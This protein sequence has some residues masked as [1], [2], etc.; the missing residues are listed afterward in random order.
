V[1]DPGADPQEGS[2]PAVVTIPRWAAILISG[3]SAAV[4][5]VHL[6]F[7]SLRIDGTT[8]ILL[9][10]AV[11]PWA[12]PLIR[13]ARLGPF[14]LNQLQVQSE[15]L[16]RAVT[17]VNERVEEIRRLVVTGATPQQQAR[18]E[19]DISRYGAYLSRI[20]IDGHLADPPI[21]IVHDP[22]EMAPGFLSEYRDGTIF[23]LAEYADRPTVALREYTHHAL[24]ASQL[25]PSTQDAPARLIESG[26]AYYFPC[27]FA[28]DGHFGR[29]TGQPPGESDGSYLQDITTPVP[30]AD[31]HASPLD[32]YVAGGHNWAVKLW[33]LRGQVRARLADPALVEAWFAGDPARRHDFEATFV[34]AVCDRLPSDQAT[35]ARH[36][37]GGRHAQKA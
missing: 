23:I 13:T 14:E 22:G 24:R 32:R 18:L 19:T 3:L 29:V 30:E 20:G 34:S 27:S 17:E 12:G 11:L 37:L 36:L 7:P 28:D 21:R 33:T 25:L 4:I 9:A 8:L 35:I 10:V 15:R 16:H 6:V 31:G 26:L 5:A 1:G 2:R